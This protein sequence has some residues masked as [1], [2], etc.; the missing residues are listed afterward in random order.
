VSFLRGR[1]RGQVGEAWVILL[2]VKEIEGRFDRGGQ[3]DDRI[4]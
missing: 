3:N 1:F 4:D 2:G